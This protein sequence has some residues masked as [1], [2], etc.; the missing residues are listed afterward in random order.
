MASY[1]VTV[2]DAKTYR[3]IKAW[4]YVVPIIIVVWAIFKLGSRSML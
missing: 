1:G 4:Y 3:I 2:L